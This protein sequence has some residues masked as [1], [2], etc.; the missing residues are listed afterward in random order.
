MMNDADTKPSAVTVFYDGAC[1]LCMREIGFYRKRKNAEAIDWVD[2]SRCQGDTVATGLSKSDAL[3]RF[4]V[5]GADGTLMSGGDAFREL[6]HA[7]P[8]FRI[9]SQLFRA[10][11]S[12]WLLNKAYDAFLTVRPALQAVLLRPAKCK[13]SR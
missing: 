4:H 6:W 12:A 2:V 13:P 10:R 11:P 1:P 7:L 8:A 3:A 5:I 9:W